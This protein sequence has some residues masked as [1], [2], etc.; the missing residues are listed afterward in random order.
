M[1]GTFNPLPK[2]VPVNVTLSDQQPV[3]VDVRV[4]D[5]VL[6]EITIPEIPTP[7][8]NPTINLPDIALP[9]M[10]FPAQMAVT[11]TRMAERRIAGTYVRADAL[12][13]AGSDA[14]CI[15]ATVAGTVTLTMAAGG[16]VTISVPVG[17]TILPLSV[18]S[19]ANGT[20]TATYQGLF[21]E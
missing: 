15:S 21:T 18:S 9:D 20:A 11:L 16:S 19:A 12:S 8:F 10:Q 2:P 1:A 6:P 7:E 5:I 13:P 3:T 4:P 17:T 14:V